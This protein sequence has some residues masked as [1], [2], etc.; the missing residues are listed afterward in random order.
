VTPGD[1]RRQRHAHRR[2][3]CLLF[4]AAFLIRFLF[5]RA[6]PFLHNWDE[7]FHAL[8]ARNLMHDP[9]KPMLIANPVAAYDFRDWKANH[10]WLH[11]QPLFLWQIALSLKAF[12]V[13][14]LSLRLPSVLMGSLLVLLTFRITF[15][16]TADTAVA[17]LAA[18][19]LCFSNF[20]LALVGGIRAMDHN[21][22]A[23]G[24]YVLASLWAWAEHRRKPAW[25]WATLTGTFAGCAVLNKWLVGLTVFLGWGVDVLRSAMRRR[26]DVRQDVRHFLFALLVCGAVCVPWQVYITSHFPEEAR[27]EY[28]YNNR[29]LTEAVEGHG[30]S[31]W[32]YAEDAPELFGAW[33]WV[34][35]PVG[36]AMMAA[37]R[38][39]DRRLLAPFLAIVAFVFCFFSF[40]VKTKM[41]NYVFFVAPLCL[42]FVAFAL[43]GIQRRADSRPL[44]ALTFLAAAVLSF[45]PR[46]TLAY[47][48]ADNVTRGQRISTAKILKGLKAEL[49]P[50]VKIVLNTNELENLDLMFYANDLTA[51]PR[52]PEADLEALAAKHVPVAAFKGDEQHPL[53]DALSRYPG[54]VVLD[55]G[56]VLREVPY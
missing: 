29:H 23:F 47:F 10:V 41:N 18:V 40:A 52:I 50:G 3:L 1:G 33:L 53:P 26:S 16:L 12:G 38:T 13:S 45:D 31:A 24:F 42:G 37:S 14:E 51:Y 54:L 28:A 6:D 35:V 39:T 2:I 49:P 46:R 55:V 11:K 7:R 15:L 43:V 36:A 9:L 22:V 5:A 8:V 56:Y 32:F 30:G 27:Y 48:S 17:V 4:A 25:G 44:L 20:H 34:L 19:L 21:D